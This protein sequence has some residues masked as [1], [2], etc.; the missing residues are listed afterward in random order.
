MPP[1]DDYQVCTWAVLLWCF[2]FFRFVWASWRREGYWIPP[3]TCNS[4]RLHNLMTTLGSKTWQGPGFQVLGSSIWARNNPQ[5]LYII[6]MHVYTNVYICIY[7]KY[8]FDSCDEGLVK[9]KSTL[10]CEHLPAET[11]Q[12]ELQDPRKLYRS[13]CRTHGNC[14]DRVAGKVV[15]TMH[16]IHD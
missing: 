8:R 9:P 12:I 5:A 10:A 2:Q 6:Y 14:T 7:I 16:W 11:V 4:G 1:P 15:F 13:C 3:K